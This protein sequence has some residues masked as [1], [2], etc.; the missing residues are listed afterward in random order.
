MSQQRYLDDLFVQKDGLIRFDQYMAEALYHPRHGYY[1]SNICA[2]GRRGDFSTS[3]GLHYVLGAA[4]SAWALKEKKNSLSAGLGRRWNVIEVG[5]GDGSMASDFLRAVPALHRPLLSYHIVEVSEPLRRKQKEK[6]PRLSV[7]WHE[8][9]ASALEAC[10][11]RALIVSNELVDAFPASVV[12]WHES[13][14]QWEELYLRDQGRGVLA[15][16][17]HKFTEDRLGHTSSVFGQWNEV[18]LRDGQVCEIFW[19]Y[20]R[21]LS[22]W[23]PSWRQGAMLTID[24]G[25]YFP[26]LYE[27]NPRGTLRGYFQGVRLQGSEVYDRFGHQDLTADVNFSDLMAWGEGGGLETISLTTQHE[28]FLKMLPELEDPAYQQQDPALEFLMSPYGCG[29]AFKVLAQRRNLAR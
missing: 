13:I 20:E 1:S 25:D 7:K 22:E 23:L 4:V 8:S 10:Q 14:R 19:S 27:R 24:Y 11:G 2:I 3:S 15:E 29:G 21:W 6:L 26:K 17:F 12:R 9:M 5:A 16:E 28:F 18:P